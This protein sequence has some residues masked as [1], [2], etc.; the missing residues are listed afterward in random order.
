MQ[1]EGLKPE[2]FDG[3]I[4]LTDVSFC[5]PSRP[6]VQVTGFSA[7]VTCIPLIVPDAA[8]DFKQA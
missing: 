5:Y 6:T 8:T 1:K 2:N 7:C 3:K 4:R